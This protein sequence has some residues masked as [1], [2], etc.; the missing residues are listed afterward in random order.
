M[1]LAK[2]VVTGIVY[3]TP[4][5]GYTNN[6]VAVSSFVL[7]IGTQEET[8][9]RVISKRQSLDEIVQ[10]LSKNQKVLVEGRLQNGVS[11]MDDGSEKRVFE[12]EASTIEL[13]G[14][15]SSTDAT[16]SDDGDILTFGDIETSADS[17]TDMLIGEEEIPF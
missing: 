2:A 9:V 17:N 15:G 14:A 13:M 11:K 12:I 6:N 8:L 16:T 5:T 7:N 10:N 1:T 3:K 4:K